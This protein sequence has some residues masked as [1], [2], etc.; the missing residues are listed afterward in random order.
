MSGGKLWA[1]AFVLFVCASAGVAYVWS[2]HNWAHHQAAVDRAISPLPA[3]NP[4]VAPH[5]SSASSGAARYQN[6]RFGY[7]VDYPSPL[8]VAGNEADSGDGLKFTPE[9]GDADIRVWGEYNVNSDSPAALLNADLTNDCAGGK[10]TYQVS[11]PNLVAYSCLSPKGRVVY[12]KAIIRGD[13]LAS[14]R[15]DYA[16]SEQQTWAPVIKQM[17]DTLHLDSGS[18]EPG[19]R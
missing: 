8:L 18:P 14:V 9:K 19:A 13:T 11:K 10:A 17:A 15:F 12:A 16:A 5:P 3:T 1:A 7:A 2:G 4:V 6:A